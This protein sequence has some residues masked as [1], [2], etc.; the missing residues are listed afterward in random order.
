MQDPGDLATQALA[1][2]QMCQLPTNLQT[3]LDA[4]VRQG[5]DA[6][7]DDMDCSPRLLL[8]HKLDRIVNAPAIAGNRDT[9]ADRALRFCYWWS[10]LSSRN[11]DPFLKDNFANNTVD[12]L[13][14][15]RNHTKWG[16]LILEA[17][18]LCARIAWQ[19]SR[20]LCDPRHVNSIIQDILFFL[21]DEMRDEAWRRIQA[22]FQAPSIQNKIILTGLANKVKPKVGMVICR[23]ILANLPGVIAL[24]PDARIN[25]ERKETLRNGVAILVARINKLGRG[26][27]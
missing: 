1:L 14:F 23:T 24:M 6:L 13:P 22:I 18:W 26:H 21:I 2:S 10:I 17:L 15:V 20:L 12:M 25:Q 4:L 5:H 27:T 7:T 8:L 3:E 16:K 11:R 9:L 19:E